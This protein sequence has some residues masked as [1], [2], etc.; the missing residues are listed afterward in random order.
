MCLKKTEYTLDSKERDR[1]MA[2]NYCIINVDKYISQFQGVI[3][4]YEDVK[5]EIL[6]LKINYE[7][8]PEI[9]EGIEQAKQKIKQI[10]GV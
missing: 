8:L 7:L 6:K 5:R 4:T 9:N 10:S 3:K 2:V 1:W